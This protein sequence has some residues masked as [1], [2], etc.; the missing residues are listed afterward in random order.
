LGDF[1]HRSEKQAEEQFELIGRLYKK[2]GKLRLF[3]AA[4]IDFAFIAS[5]R[6]DGMIMFTKNLW[7]IAPGWL[8]VAEAGAKVTNLDGES[9]QFGMDEI[10]VTATDEM[11][12]IMKRK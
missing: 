3:G 4:S 11:L 6:T 10:V 8:L 12:K 1:S 9:Y 2:I 5:G 7:D